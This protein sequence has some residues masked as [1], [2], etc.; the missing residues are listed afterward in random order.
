MKNYIRNEVKRLIEKHDTNNPF[1][2]AR[3]EKII[4]LYE[5]LGNINGYYNKYAR[6]KFIHINENLDLCKQYLTCTHEL[7]HA[8]IH[9]DSNTPFFRDNSFY[10]I[11]KLERQANFFSAELIINDNIIDNHVLLTYSIEQ[12]SIF[13]NVPIEL[14]KLKFNL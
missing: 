14:I 7:G 8:T 12:L 10:S 2:I 3:G 9:P 6:Q 11:N 1:D 13:Y 4:V 5:N